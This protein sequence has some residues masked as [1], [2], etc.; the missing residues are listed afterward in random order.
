M[1]WLRTEAT[2]ARHK[3]RFFTAED[4]LIVFVNASKINAAF[5]VIRRH[6]IRAVDFNEAVWSGSDADMRIAKYI[7]NSEL[8]DGCK[9]DLHCVR[10]SLPKL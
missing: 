8:H 2:A 6:S 4:L 1:K 10:F 9:M 7:Q 5:R 3:E